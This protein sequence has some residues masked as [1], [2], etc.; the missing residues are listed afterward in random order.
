MTLEADL[1]EWVA[2]RPDWQK[3]AVAR[4]CRNESLSRRSDAGSSRTS[5][6]LGCFARGRM[7]A[8]ER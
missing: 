1:A 2:G 7:L 8:E 4:F 5:I 3:Q 6:A